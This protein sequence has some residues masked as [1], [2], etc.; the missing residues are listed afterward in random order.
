MRRTPLSQS[1]ILGVGHGS[2]VYPLRAVGGGRFSKKGGIPT[3][4]K[5]SGIILNRLLLQIFIVKMLNAFFHFG[6]NRLKKTRRWSRSFHHFRRDNLERREF[7]DVYSFLIVA[8]TTYHK[9]SVLKQ[10]KFILLQSLREEIRNG[11]YRAK[12]KYWQSCVTF[13]GSMG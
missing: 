1:A 2:E 10:C 8:V 11:S 12:I 6:G 7:W 5:Y 13:E 4:P 9:L 3:C